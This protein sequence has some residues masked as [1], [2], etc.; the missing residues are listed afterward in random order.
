MI[1]ASAPE[2][3]ATKSS[4]SIIPFWQISDD[5]Y[6]KARPSKRPLDEDAHSIPRVDPV[7]R[8]TTMST[9]SGRNTVPARRSGVGFTKPKRPGV[10]VGPGMKLRAEGDLD[11]SDS[12]MDEDIVERP[13]CAVFQV[14]QI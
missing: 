10:Y 4:A 12:P 5:E 6:T 9:A 2:V 13:R 1:T 7:R 11:D 3:V 14:V 8:R